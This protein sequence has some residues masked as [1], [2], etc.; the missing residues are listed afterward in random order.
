MR[1]LTNEEFIDRV[2]EVRGNTIRPLT[3]YHNSKT[4]V[5]AECGECN[6][7]W[8]CAPRT[9]FNPHVYKDGCPSCGPGWTRPADLA[10]KRFTNL[11]AIEKTGTKRFSFN[12]WRCQCVCG[13]VLEV[14]SNS[15]LSGNTKS[16]GC[17]MRQPP[18]HSGFKIV[19]GNYVR[20]SRRRNLDFT[21]TQEEFIDLVTKNCFYCGSPPDRITYSRQNRTRIDESPAVNR[22]GFTHLGIDRV[23][24]NSGYSIENCVPC[25][26]PCNTAKH[27]RTQEDFFKWIQR[28]YKHLEEQSRL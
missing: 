16:C 11:T 17:L 23:N 12:V 27:T 9:L 25:C 7:R 2:R 4:P 5:E 22:T 13:T 26:Q 18:G 1:R 3:P 10:G 21:L 6:H 8:L 14:N 28:A 24:N 20:D 19:W 15:L